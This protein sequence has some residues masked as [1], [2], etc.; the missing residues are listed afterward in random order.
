MTLRVSKELLAATTHEDLAMA[1]DN[2]SRWRND[3]YDIR[4]RQLTDQVLD[5]LGAAAAKVG[6]RTFERVIDAIKRGRSGDFS[7]AIPSWQAAASTIRDYLVADM[8]DGWVYRRESDGH[9]YAYLVTKIE[10]ISEMSSGSSKKDE[11]V[12]LTLTANNDDGGR[13]GVF[14]TTIRLDKEDV[15]RRK[16]AD[17]L[18]SI[19]LLKETPELKATYLEQTE[20]YRE[21]LTEGFAQQYRFTGKVLKNYTKVTV[22]NRRVVHDIAPNEIKAFAEFGSTDLLSSA[23]GG[24]AQDTAPVPIRPMLRI[25]DLHDHS[26]H[27]VNALGLTEYEYDTSLREKLIL[28][29]NHRELLD[30][31]TTDIATFTGDIIEGKSAGNVILCKGTPGLGKTLTAEVYAELIKRP[32]YAIHSGSLG[33]EADQVR[34]NLEII[35]QRAD[36]WQ[37]VILLDE[38][39]VFVIERGTNLQQNAIVAEFLRVLEYQTSLAF[40][41]TNRANEIDDAILSRCAA[42]IS[43]ELPSSDDAKRIW[44]VLSDNINFGLTDELIDGL[45]AAFPKASPRDI[46]MLVRLVA[47]IARKRNEEPTVDLFRQAAMF[48]GM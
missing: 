20:R 10:S 9:V 11:Y 31:L 32:L 42:I 29:E 19:N 35:F 17:I 37:A 46:K 22:E 5:D 45:A 38:A 14:R 30:I 4:D 7:K 33:I 27:T 21:V 2:G 40:L 6:D 12:Q 43:Y 3:E 24:K 15:S 36:R 23:L 25:F 1:R 34:K 18:A 16:V 39:D 44:R 28:P 13:L 8:I 41:T 48:R 47:R 26:F